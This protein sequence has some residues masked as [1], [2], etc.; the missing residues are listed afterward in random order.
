M[1][2]NNTSKRIFQRKN[3][4]T[5][6]TTFWEDA[7]QTVPVTPLDITLY[8]AYTIYDINN[9]AVQSGV[10]QPVS[11]PGTYK[12]EYLVPA[13]APL[14]WDEKRWRIEWIVVSTEN[15]QF[16][17]IEEFDVR[18]EVQTQSTHR[19]QR[20]VTLW[21]QDFRTILRLTNEPAELTVNVYQ[22]VSNTIVDSASL[23]IGIKKSIEGDSIVYYHDIPS[24]ALGQ[25]QKFSIIW[26]IRDTTTSVA[27]FTYMSLSSITPSV[28]AQVTSV[29]MLIDKFQKRLGTVQAYE[30][31]D[32]VEYLERGSEL[33]NAGF[34][35]TWY[36]FGAMPTTL[37]IF[38]ILM[39]AWYGL[40]AQSLL[41][42]D[43][44]F[45]FTGQTVTLDYDHASAISDVAGR[46]SDFISTNMPAA[47]MAVV[48]AS[49]Q[50]GTTAGRA[51]R[52]SS[53][54]LTY[55]VASYGGSTS[56]TSDNYL[57]M[58]T[59]MGLLW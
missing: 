18:D 11:T 41:E 39:A 25:N 51:Y 38:V 40:Q 55:K 8:P 20:Y 30:E 6:Q 17:M 26:S 43:L 12:A 46:W 3:L 2:I 1:A 32:I 57:G 24:S 21:N 33:V 44:G 28:L 49:R 53:Q 22:G 9:F 50:A 23:N 15:R 29:R 45:N 7:N 34:P 59:R 35:T 31:S 52:N 14:S 5:F 47:K 10:G 4:A 54:F 36:T 42:T 58:M 48:R 16:D 19:E 56:P 37:N 27:E 13:D